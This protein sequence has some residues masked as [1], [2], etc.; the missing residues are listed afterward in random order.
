MLKPLDYH[1]LRKRYPYIVYRKKAATEISKIQIRSDVDR[2]RMIVE[3]LIK[4]GT[5]IDV[6][7]LTAFSRAFRHGLAHI[8]VAKILVISVYFG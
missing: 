5:G 1:R 8:D 4:C 7:S 3:P 6:F 2:L